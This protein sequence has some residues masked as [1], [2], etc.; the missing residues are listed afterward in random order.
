MFEHGSSYMRKLM[1]I[2]SALLKRKGE[3]KIERTKAGVVFWFILT[4]CE[5]ICPTVPPAFAPLL[6][7]CAHALVAVKAIGAGEETTDVKTSFGGERREREK[8][9]R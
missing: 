6:G 4:C 7:M 2:A 1:C 9:G 3:K 8:G 5:Q